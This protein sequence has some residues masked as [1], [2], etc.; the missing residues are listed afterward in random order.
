[1]P[2]SDVLLFSRFG[3]TEGRWVK[4]VEE[5]FGGSPEGVGAPI[6]NDRFRALV[7]AFR[8]RGAVRDKQ[9]NPDRVGDS[10]S[11]VL[12]RQL[13]PAARSARVLDQRLVPGSPRPTVQEANEV[14]F[15]AIFRARRA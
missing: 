12:V 1:L 9:A 14:A 3:V 10:V 5:G 15:R 6:A 4:T 11:Q 13:L 8:L 2:A 7:G